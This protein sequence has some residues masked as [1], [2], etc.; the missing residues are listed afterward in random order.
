[1]PEQPSRT[2]EVDPGR[3]DEATRARLRAEFGDRL[4]LGPAL[5]V[6]LTAELAVAVNPTA[7]FARWARANRLRALPVDLSAAA[8]LVGPLAVPDRPGGPC[9]ARARRGA[10]ERAPGSAVPERVA[11]LVDDLVDR[12]AE[13]PSGTPERVARLV[14]DLLDRGAAGPPGTPAPERVARP[15]GG[16]LDRLPS[17]AAAV[18]E[19]VARLIGDLLDRGADDLVD[20]VAELTE[21]GG[22]LWHR[23]VPLPSCPVCGG[24]AAAGARPGLPDGDDVDAL[25]AALA[26]WLDPLTGVIATVT[27]HRPL[28][29]GLP[30]AAT[31]SPPR[32]VDTRGAVRTTPVGRGRGATERDAVLTAVAEAV[33]RYS[34]SL[35]DPDRLVWARPSDLDGDVLD[36]REFPQLDP[37]SYGTPGSGCVP[38]DRRLDH[39]WVRGTWLDSGGPVWVPAVHAYLAMPLLPEHRIAQATT[40]GLAAGADPDAAALR[41]VLELVERDAFHATWLTGGRGRYVDLDDTLDEDLHD[42]V[43]ALTALG[44]AVEVHTL[45]T[46][47]YG[48]TALALALG[49][50]RRWPGAALGLA[51]D[52]SPRAAIRAALLELATTAPALADVLRTGS[53]AIPRTSAE[54]R[55]P[56]DHATLYFPTSAVPA[57]DRLRTGGTTPLSALPEPAFPTTRD[58]LA[59]TLS[60]KGI[61]VA[62]VDVTS[63]DTATGPF[64]VVRAV[65]ADLQPTTHGYAHRRGLVARHRRAG[66]VPGERPAHPLW[67]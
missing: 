57:F 26:G 42:L 1:M 49:D 9:C 51:A 16:L 29:P 12:G 39:P 38:F 47:A 65:S 60:T 17:A 11:R 8:P 40:A 52:R 23:V 33:E 37:L 36:P 61:R 66:V 4:L 14:D 55:T 44:P 27:A 45:P 59:A 21:A 67:H 56:F 41:A 32:A 5:P 34:A 30:H 20:H 25:R 53:P 63:A 64:R 58:H 7:G 50:G 54:V 13:H 2:A 3:L 15:A 28:G 62:L 18:P 31:T 22:V 35:P 19:R 43:G 48:T 10:A 24:A 46:T 6:P